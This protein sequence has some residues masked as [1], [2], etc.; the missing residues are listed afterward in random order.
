MTGHLVPDKTPWKAASEQVTVGHDNHLQQQN[1][2][3]LRV[4]FSVLFYNITNDLLTLRAQLF[5]ASLA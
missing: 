2:L 3:S 4:F 1:Q 5:K